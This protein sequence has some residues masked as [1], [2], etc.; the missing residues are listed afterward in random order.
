MDYY[1]LMFH[2][3]HD[4]THEPGQ[5][6]I[7]AEEFEQ[8]LNHVGINNVMP[9]DEWLD[10]YASARY[11]DLKGKY[12]I[13]FDDNLRCQYDIALPVLEKYNIKAFWFVYTSPVTGEVERLELYR[14]V[15]NKF[16]ASMSDFY[17]M[18]FYMMRDLMGDSFFIESR[19][20]FEDS[21]YLVDYTFYT[22]EDREYRYYRDE[23]LSSQQYI[24]I[25]D[26]IV[27]HYVSDK[28]ALLNHL[29]MDE[30]CLKELNM[31]GH[32][33]GLHS[34]TH[35]TRMDK[36]PYD[37]Q[38]K[39]YTQNYDILTNIL[40]AKP[41]VMSHPSNSYNPDTIKILDDFSIE[42][43][44]RADLS[45]DKFS[46]LELPREDHSNIIRQI[47]ELESV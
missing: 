45:M 37:E 42:L 46:S 23:L 34:H 29:W 40:G 12:C 2:H 35:P 9:A 36:L 11:S 26:R 13:T 22:N 6:S 20:V 4:V 33:V 14:Y 39:E 28:S 15:R 30:D 10:C 5:G 32:I 27:E 43:G 7:S 47:K 19:K 1:G 3:F 31:K 21:N 24:E 44:F 17:S 38:L 8:I 16:F 25:M 18:F 41:R